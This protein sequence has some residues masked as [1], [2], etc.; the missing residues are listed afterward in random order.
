MGGAAGHMWHPFDCPDVNTGT[1]LIAFY[2]KVAEWVKVNP[3]ALKIDGVNASF[4]L[5]DSTDH[6]SG[7]EFA[8]DRGSSRGEMG[9]L[10]ISGITSTK[11]HMRWP[12]G[13][14]M[15]EATR[16]LLGIFNKALPRIESEL[17]V[18]G[19]WDDP[20]LFF[21]TEFVLRKTNVKEYP[22]NFIAI[23][24]VKQFFQETPKK[25]GS[26]GVN[27]DKREK[28]AIESIKKKVIPIA[29][30]V[31]APGDE[32]VE[33]ED[34]G[35]KIY[36][37]IPTKSIREI[38]FS[39]SL[40]SEFKVVFSA[41][42]GA[43]DSEIVKTL[44]QW[45]SEATN[46]RHYFVKL[47]NDKKIGALSKQMYTTIL[48]GTPITEF[49]ENGD[50]VTPGIY[51]AVFTHAVRLLGNDV[52]FSLDSELGPAHKEEG[53][54]IKDETMCGGTEFK[55]T[56]EFIVGGIDSPFRSPKQ[57]PDITDDP[58]ADIGLVPGAFKPPH[59]GHKFMVDEMTK[60]ARKVIV[61]ISK[62]L[63]QARTMPSGR[64][65]TADL[66]RDI[67]N[68]YIDDPN[69]E[70]HISENAS[71]ITS[72]ME[73]I[74]PEGPLPIKSTVLL[75][76][77]E[78]GKDLERFSDAQKYARED[79]YI[80]TAPCAVKGHA[81]WYNALLGEERSAQVRQGMPSVVD[82]K[83]PE[84]F[85]GSDMRY[86]AELAASD[87]V[88]EELF[89]DFVTE[90]TDHTAVLNILGIEKKRPISSLGSG[91]ADASLS[92]EE[93]YNTIDDI[94]TEMRGA[95]PL[96]SLKVQQKKMRT[97]NKIASMMD[98]E[99]VEEVPAVVAEEELEEVSTGAV[100]GLE[101]ASAVPRGGPEAAHSKVAYVLRKSKEEKREE[102][103]RGRSTDGSTSN[104]ASWSTTGHLTETEEVID[105]VVNYLVKNGVIKDDI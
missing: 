29:K 50:D 34:R 3:A 88:A 103:R 52:L 16:T 23:H 26:L 40:A 54:V 21:N 20:S 63:R 98:R 67:W 47:R 49:I 92:L 99:E 15:I 104:V 91:L 25:R 45:L 74:G 61:L 32:E 27:L 60:R 105:Q 38:D 43:P 1:D 77:S 14:G 9:Q 83:N 37:T 31:H 89:R 13:H 72:V 10:D 75:G 12:E 76:C 46:P 71:P 39:Q 22:F 84:E 95:G 69:V 68:M 19:M 33:E 78:K 80:E 42:S 35:F 58:I 55:I 24:G 82:G 81:P 64:E 48:S 65:I 17:K 97:M 7:K 100:G 94:M 30:E 44:Q 87:E 62:P 93:I 101:G 51:G 8:L 73:Y 41:D 102:D 66:S 96:I 90:N 85:H 59:R 11:A 70:I 57:D 53:I 18:L 56:G 86:V 6:P 5:I 79:V 4:K 2:E 36:T 28:Q